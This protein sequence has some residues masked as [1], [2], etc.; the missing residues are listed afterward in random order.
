MDVSSLMN[1]YKYFANVITIVRKIPFGVKGLDDMLK[2]GLIENRVYLIKGGPGS[3]K[4]I[5]SIQFLVEGVKRNENVMYVSLEESIEEVREEMEILGIDTSGISFVDSSFTGEKSIFSEAYL[6][7][8]E[9]DLQ[10]FKIYLENEIDKV[11]PKRLVIDPITILRL[12]SKSEVEYRRNLL[13]LIT[14]LRKRKITTLITTEF[15]GRCVEDYIVSGVIELHCYNVKGRTVRGVKIVKFRGSDF[16]EVIRPYTIKQG[17]LEV[18]SEV[19][20]FD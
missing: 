11:K 1:I 17:G 20:L 2:G 19:K 7:N 12:A 4:T 10:T 9:L 6:I 18:Y 8:S 14:M 3:G 13:A 5:L 16:D 15:T